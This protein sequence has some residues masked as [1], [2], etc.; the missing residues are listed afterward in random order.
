MPSSLQ[1]IQKGLL[2]WF[3]TNLVNIHP[4]KLALVD[5]HPAKLALKPKR[6]S[7]PESQLIT[8]IDS[9]PTPATP[10]SSKPS[11]VTEVATS[12]GAGNPLI[13]PTTSNGLTPAILKARLSG[14]KIKS[15]HSAA[16]CQSIDL[17]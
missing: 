8:A 3:G 4:A 17:R 1:G 12:Y 2:K 16:S 11:P 15:V 7:T 9:Y 5:I 14:K 10:S 13:F 6:E